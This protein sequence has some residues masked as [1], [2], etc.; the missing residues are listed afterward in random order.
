MEGGLLVVRT[1][2][3]RMP[4]CSVGAT[5]EVAYRLGRERA[6]AAGSTPQLRIPARLGRLD[7]LVPSARHTRRRWHGRIREY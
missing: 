1:V 4:V 2:R 5:N 3:N 7:D 6:V